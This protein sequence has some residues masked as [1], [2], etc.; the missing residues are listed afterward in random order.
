MARAS[1]QY[2]VYGIY[3]KFTHPSTNTTH[4]LTRPTFSVF[5][6]FFDFSSAP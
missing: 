5:G 1:E 2:G 3:I 6:F 4:G